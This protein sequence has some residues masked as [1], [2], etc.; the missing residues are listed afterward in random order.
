MREAVGY[1]L[2]ALILIVGGAL[3]RT[4]ILNWICGPAIVVVT[5]SLVGGWL[6]KRRERRERREPRQE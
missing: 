4:P 5:V 6:D 3:V 2:A 1:V